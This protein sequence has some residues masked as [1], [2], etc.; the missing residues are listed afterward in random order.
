MDNLFVNEAHKRITLKLRVDVIDRL[1]GG[2][3]GTAYLLEDGRVMKV[4]RDS[5]EYLQSTEL[6][7]KNI[8]HLVN[9]FETY[10]VKNNKNIHS[11][12]YVIL[13]EKLDTSCNKTLLKFEEITG[14]NEEVKSFVG[15]YNEESDLDKFLYTLIERYPHY[16]EL[17][18]EYK[19]VGM[20]QKEAGF[21]RSD[22]FAN[23]LGR[24]NGVLTA[25]DFG[26]SGKNGKCQENIIEI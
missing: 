23:N 19:A 8:K 26:Y 20:A 11:N 9:I 13:Q 4:T 24:K 2:K 14:F 21:K 1:G 16:E 12:E 25:F 7:S 22:M 5:S 18:L 17:A 3:N 10:V 6:K 15:G